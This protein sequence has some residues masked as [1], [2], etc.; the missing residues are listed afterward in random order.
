MPINMNDAQQVFGF[1]ANQSLII[2]REVYETRYPEYDYGR[3]IFV[4]ESSPEW[5]GGILTFTSDTTGKARWY[6][7]GAKDVPFADVNRSS[8]EKQ[9]HTAAIGYEY[10]EAEV[11]RAVLESRNLSG[12]RAF[13]ARR[14]YEQ[15]MYAVAIRGDTEKGLGGLVNSSVVTAA[16]VPND[17]TGASRLWSTKTPALIIRDINLGLVATFTDSATVE[18]ADT[19]LLPI[20]GLSYLAET[21]F[22]GTT[23]T[24]ILKFIQENNIYTRETGQPLTIRGVRGLENDGAGGTGRMVTYKNDRTVA[25]LHLPMRHRFARAW[26]DGPYHY[27]IPGM[28]RTGGVEILRPKAFRYLDGITA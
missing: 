16:N 13:A 10:D 22:N 8:Q 12:D 18:M 6:N 28:F 9:F 15:F 20:E 23:D 27:V 17:G 19:V 11:G 2:N 24:T 3:L 4:D 1:V 25:K 26:Q 21:P 14:A 7:P 5:A